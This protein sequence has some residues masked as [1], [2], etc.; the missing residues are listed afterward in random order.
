MEALLKSLIILRTYYAKL[1]A[2]MNNGISVGTFEVAFL[3][4]NGLTGS[5]FGQI[6]RLLSLKLCVKES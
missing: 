5:A 1:S 4:V 3:K 6:R 2:R